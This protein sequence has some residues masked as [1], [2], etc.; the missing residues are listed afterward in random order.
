MVTLLGV[1]LS[2]MDQVPQILDGFEG[3]F[4]VIAS[5]PMLGLFGFN[6]GLIGCGLTKS[7]AFN[8]ILP[9]VF[10]IHYMPTIFNGGGTSCAGS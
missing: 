1:S 5:E 6:S 9:F 10:V 4:D 3:S 2:S 8:V 7:S